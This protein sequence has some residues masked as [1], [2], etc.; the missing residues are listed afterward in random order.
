MAHVAHVVHVI[1]VVGSGIGGVD[2]GR[3]VIVVCWSVVVG[4]VTGVETVLVF[5]VVGRGG[6]VVGG[7]GVVG[8]VFSK[9]KKD[10]SKGGRYVCVLVVG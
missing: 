10:L 1:D 4:R 2:V 6:V 3:V 9:R 8:R 7:G 5:T